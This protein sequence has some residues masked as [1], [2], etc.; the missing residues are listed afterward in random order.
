M[1]A[2]EVRGMRG[3]VRVHMLDRGALAMQDQVVE[4]IQDQGAVSGGQCTSVCK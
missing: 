3:Q 2:L 1:L 4:H